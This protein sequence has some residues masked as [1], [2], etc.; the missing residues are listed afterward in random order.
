MAFK[1]ELA[2]LVFSINQ[3]LTLTHEIVAIM[4]LMSEH[5][6]KKYNL[7]KKEFV[8]G[9]FSM[10]GIFSMRYAE[11]AVQDSTLTRIKPLAVFSCDGP[12]DLEHIY[13]NFK[14]KAN[15]NPRLNEPY[16]GMKELEKYC[17]GT[18]ETH[19]AQYQYYSPYSHN[20]PEGG[21]AKY[22]L[23]L[24]LRIYADVDP[25]WW[26]KNRH[27]DMY[28]LNALDQTA[29][30]QLLNDLGNTRAEFINAYQKGVRIEGNR[31]PHA[32][33]IIDSLDCVQWIEK[34]LTNK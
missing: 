22:L 19:L 27:V 16:Y 2:V 30:I 4:N 3:R 17:G 15:K 5:A 8:F 28:D 25:S 9:G 6:L 23:K 1:K 11:L 14:K 24:P 33:S 34:C 12:C 29:V 31:H 18:P 32:W 7:E 20:L 26:M 13:H 21:N 10:G